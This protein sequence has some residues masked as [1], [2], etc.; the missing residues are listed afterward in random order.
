MMDQEKK[1][2]TVVHY[3]NTDILD[4][5]VKVGDVLAYSVRCGSY[6]K[7]HFGKVYEITPWRDECG[8]G[9]HLSLYTG[10]SIKIIICSESFHY[11]NCTYDLD[12]KYQKFLNEQ[13]NLG[14]V[15][16]NWTSCYVKFPRK[17][18]IGLTRAI[19]IDPNLLPQH[20]KRVLLDEEWIIDNIR[21]A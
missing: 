9:E 7:M 20:L 2:K 21:V 12:S 3:P 10:Y 14:N 1:Y 5:E 15:P 18:S 8:F 19:I 11:V 6:H 16:A 13:I 4:R 17:T